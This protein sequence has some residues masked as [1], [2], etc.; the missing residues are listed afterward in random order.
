[1][2]GFS[3]CSGR[4]QGKALSPPRFPPLF[5]LYPISAIDRTKAGINLLLF[6]ALAL[7]QCVHQACTVRAPPDT[8]FFEQSKVSRAGGVATIRSLMQVNPNK[9]QPVRTT[10][11]I[12]LERPDPVHRKSDNRR[13]FSDIRTE[14]AADQ[15]SHRIVQQTVCET[16]FPASAKSTTEWTRRSIWLQTSALRRYL[17]M[18]AKQRIGTAWLFGRKTPFQ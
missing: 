3:L 10:D 12:E 7:A 9:V 6:C 8:R 5:P 15:L 1:M 13:L 16:V 17:P 14:L 4:V 11:R 2:I 18:C